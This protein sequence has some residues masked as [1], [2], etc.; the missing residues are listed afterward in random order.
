MLEEEFGMCEPPNASARFGVASLFSY[1]SYSMSY[2]LSIGLPSKLRIL[3]P[4]RKSTTQAPEPRRSL[5]FSKE[6]WE[7]VWSCDEDDVIMV[8]SAESP[9][10]GVD[11]PSGSFLFPDYHREQDRELDQDV[12]TPTNGTPWSSESDGELTPLFS[13]NFPGTLNPNALRC[14]GHPGGKLLDSVVPSPIEPG[15]PSGWWITNGTCGP[16]YVDD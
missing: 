6:T 12:S 8:E 4:K 13:S 5:S 2:P 16:S 3:P 14:D 15:T 1:H 11:T 7:T 10:E 9:L